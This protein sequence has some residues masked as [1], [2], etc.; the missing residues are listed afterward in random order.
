MKSIQF[1]YIS[2]FLLLV[3]CGDDTSINPDLIG[4]WKTPGA[5]YTFF[6]NE[7]YAI[8][9]INDGGKNAPLPIAFLELTYMTTNVLSSLLTKKDIVLIHHK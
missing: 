2:L 4:T 5:T 3:S 7:N 6:E 9:Y 1:L 8:E